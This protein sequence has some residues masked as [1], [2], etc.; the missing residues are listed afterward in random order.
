M[1]LDD[2]VSIQFA[3]ANGLPAKMAYTISEVSLFSGM[4]Q[5]SI[6]N[7]EKQGRLKFFLPEGSSRG[8]LIS[9]KELDRYFAQH[10]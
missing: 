6:R 7:E 10:A 3:M 8:A 2:S 9:V 4:S 1:S 5:W